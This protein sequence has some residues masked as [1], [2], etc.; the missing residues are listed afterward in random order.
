MGTDGQE[1]LRAIGVTEQEEAVYRVLLR[2][3]GLSASEIAARVSGIPVR[4]VATIAGRLEGKGLINRVAGQEGLFVPA[5]PE[6][7]VEALILRR[8]EH[9]ERARL[10]ARRME[11]TF[12]AARQ[13]RPPGP[14]DVVEVVLGAEAVGQRFEQIVSGA[15]TRIMVFDRPPFASAPGSVDPLEIEAL[16]RGIEN[17]SIYDPQGLTLPGR[18]DHLRTVVGAG[19]QARVL[20]G[21]PMKLFIADDRVAFIPLSL[22]EP[23]MEG[24]LLVQPSPVLDALIT[25]FEAL[26]ERAVPVDFSGEWSLPPDG[27]SSVAAST[28]DADLM[29]LLR[30]G[31]KDQAIARQL[32]VSHRTILRR[33]SRVMETL[34]A[35]TRFQAG[36][37]AAR[38]EGRDIPD[39]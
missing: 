13:R 25:L 15:R 30:S 37:L 39:S 34:G 5:P 9:L 8:Q 36:W 21:L 31:L 4:R 20:A 17:R 12:R 33:V 29:M 1:A 27:R 28:M 14:L 32:G 18:I 10:E 6:V 3:P 26:W 23:G 38:A 22:D 7:A 19:E 24:A 11:A 2:R 16:E 35:T